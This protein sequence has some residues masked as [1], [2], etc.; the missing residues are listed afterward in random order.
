MNDKLYD[1]EGNTFGNLGDDDFDTEDFDLGSS[2]GTFDNLSDEEFEPD[3]EA[4]EAPQEE[5][6]PAED[7]TAQRLDKF[8]QNKHLLIVSILALLLTGKMTAMRIMQT[9]TK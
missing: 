3:M 1:L 2:D 5:S 6:E 8:L 4:A 9:L 7:N